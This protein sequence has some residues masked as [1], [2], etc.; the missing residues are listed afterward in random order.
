MAQWP[1]T[2]CP[3]LFMSTEV[4]ECHELMPHSSDTALTT[5]LPV[6]LFNSVKDAERVTRGKKE[7]V[8][9]KKKRYRTVL[10]QDTWSHF[11]L[12]TGAL[13][14]LTPT[15]ANLAPTGNPQHDVMTF[16][17]RVMEGERQGLCVI[18]C[19]FHVPSSPVQFCLQTLTQDSV[20]ALLRHSSTSIS[21][22]E[23][24]AAPECRQLCSASWVYR[25]V[26]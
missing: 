17:L 9:W 19:L 22:C 16:P 5:M 25:R 26:S 2:L 7:G 18:L 1:H 24:S 8:N 23:P 14:T 10:Y 13:I 15:S 11:L 3:N 12:A 6:S 21:S 4:H 20:I